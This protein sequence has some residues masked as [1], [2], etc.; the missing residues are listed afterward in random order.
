[1]TVRRATLPLAML[2]LLFGCK[3]REKS[4]SDFRP[5]PTPAQ[6]QSGEAHFVERCARCHGVNAVGTDSGPPL[7]HDVYRASHHGD[8]AFELAVRNGVRAH[9]WRFGDM[10]PQPSVTPDDVRLITAYVRW[11][12][13]QARGQRP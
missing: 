8:G 2:V 12:Q 1:L 3:S 7:V 9:H 4:F 13:M 5:P 6:L 10:P 11:L